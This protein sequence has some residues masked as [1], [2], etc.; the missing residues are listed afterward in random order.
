MHLQPGP[1]AVEL[2]LSGQRFRAILTA[3]APYMYVLKIGRDVMS[4]THVDAGSNVDGDVGSD[5]DRDVAGARLQIGIATLAAGI[6]QLNGDST[7]T[8]F[9]R[10]RRYTVKLNAASTGF[11]VHVSFGGRQANATTTGFNLRGAADIAE[12]HAAA[13][14]PT[15][16]P[17]HCSDER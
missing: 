16:L 12:V 15:L 17:C 8:G 10:R 1:A 7:G 13:A 6:H 14:G 9:C 2:A 4:A 3:L 11:G 5:V